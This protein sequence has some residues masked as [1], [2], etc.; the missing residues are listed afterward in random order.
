MKIDMFDLSVEPEFECKHCGRGP[1]QHH[2]KWKSC[3]HG[4]SRNFPN[5]SK[6][7]TYEASGVETKASKKRGKS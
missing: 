6:T 7:K 2:A 1:G 3:P 5:W 4:R